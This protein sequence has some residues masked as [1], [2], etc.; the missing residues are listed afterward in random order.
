MNVLTILVQV[1]PRSH[2]ENIALDGLL[3]RERSYTTIFIL[4][5]PC[6]KWL[7]N[8]CAQKPEV[9]FLKWI[10]EKLA[11]LRN[12]LKSPAHHYTW[13]YRKY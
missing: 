6:A 7:L 9:I 1:A 4:I 10:Q 8:M 11:V 5:Q 2:F 3:V 12:I 13:S